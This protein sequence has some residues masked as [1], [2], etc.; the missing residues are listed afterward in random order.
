MVL[1]LI[2][3]IAGTFAATGLPYMV[4]GGQAVLI[5]GEPRL[6]RDIDIT[7]GLDVDRFEE[8]VA[9]ATAAGLVTLVAG[10]EFTRRTNVLPCRHQTSGLRVDLI[11]SFSPYE[12]QAVARA[13]NVLVGGTAVRFATAEDLIIHK[14]VAG[15]PR[16]VED[17][18]SV[19]R[20]R[21][22]L[23]EAYLKRW[24]A[25]FEPVVERPLWPTYQELRSGPDSDVV[26]QG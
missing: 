4:I 14:L 26:E 10:E 11:F 2:E 15:R 6:T 18:R 17:V 8:V 12:R 23:D 21:P 16:D 3:G 7:L 25:E 22:D 9:A 5:H 24:L 19:L 20:R 13:E 1:D